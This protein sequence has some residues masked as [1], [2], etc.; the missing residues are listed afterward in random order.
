M[1]SHTYSQAIKFIEQRLNPLA[2]ELDSIEECTGTL[3]SCQWHTD[4]SATSEMYLQKMHDYDKRLTDISI[5]KSTIAELENLF[6][7]PNLK[8]QIFLL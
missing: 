6:K 7:N 5:L 1:I 8:K 4:I 2:K 3:Q